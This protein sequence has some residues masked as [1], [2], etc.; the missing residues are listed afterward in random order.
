MILV[1]QD[2]RSFQRHLED[3]G[4]FRRSHEGAGVPEGSFRDMPAVFDIEPGDYPGRAGAPAF[5]RVRGRSTIVPIWKID[6]PG[7]SRN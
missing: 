2:V 3:M 7:G 4:R 1:W 6:L 5:T